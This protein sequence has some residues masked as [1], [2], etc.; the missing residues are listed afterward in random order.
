[1]GWLRQKYTREYFLQRDAAGNRLSYGVHGVEWWEKGVIYPEAEDI[2]SS[3]DL[4]AAMVLDVGFGRG[5]AIRYCVTHGARHVV[6]VDFAEVTLEIAQSTTLRGI[7]STQYTLVNA[8]ILDYLADRSD[9]CRF[10]HILMLDV[11]EHIPRFETERILPDLFRRLVPGGCLVVHTPFG[12]E[13]DDLFITGGKVSCKDSSDLC[14]ETK[15]MHINRY[16]S[17]G[18]AAQLGRHRFCRWTDYV[19]VRRTF[20]PM[21]W[22]RGLGRRTLARLCGYRVR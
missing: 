2:L 11:I 5:E 19:F 10:S 16:S 21:C 15:G 8:D 7:S 20:V 17:A 12:P 18:L 4:R 6:G 9:V 13:D 1:M 3:L 22:Y 14:D